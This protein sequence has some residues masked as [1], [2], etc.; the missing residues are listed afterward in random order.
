MKEAII[1]AGGFGTR[2]KSEV[3]LL[4]KA[5]APINGRP[6]I[7][8][9]LDY[10][11][12]NQ[13]STVILAVGYGH[14]E[15]INTLGNRYNNIELLYSIEE[16]PLGTGGAI[17]LAMEAS[18]SD[19]IYVFNGDTLA[20][21]N[22]KKL[23]NEWE[24]DKLPIIVGIQSSDTSRYGRLVINKNRVTKFEE[25]VDVG[26]GIINSGCYI[27]NKGQL[28]QYPLNFPFSIEKNYLEK[29]LEHLNF[30][31]VV[32]DGFFIDIGT[33]SD[34]KKL[35]KYGVEKYLKE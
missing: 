34:F 29:N 5:L 6:F 15:I 7:Y 23:E 31:A 26:P 28:N 25:K 2:L 20:N 35:N 13:F 24:S 9:L 3:P 22:I 30:K 33:P 21:I 17:R 12:L 19:H 18:K 16:K 10:L 27:F 8:Y 11:D 4:P 32:F 14:N 1:L